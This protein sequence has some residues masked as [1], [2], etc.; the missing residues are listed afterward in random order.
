M[1]PKASIRLTLHIL[2]CDRRRHPTYDGST[3]LF[4]RGAV[5]SVFP[6]HR[7]S[8]KNLRD[9]R[10]LS[11]LSQSHLGYHSASYVL[12]LRVEWAS[13]PRVVRVLSGLEAFWFPTLERPLSIQS[14][15][16]N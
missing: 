7:E 2:S 4:S 9:N 3:L 15:W 13:Y 8:P 10:D 16:Q 14:K 5:V 12:I 11:Q 1:S 6:F